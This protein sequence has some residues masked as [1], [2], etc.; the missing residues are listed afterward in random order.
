MNLSSEEEFLAKKFEG[1][2]N[3]AINSYKMTITKF[4]NLREQEILTYIIGQNSGVFLKFSNI[5][6][7]DE[8]KRAIISPFEVDDDFDIDIIKLDYN[9]KFSELNHRQILGTIMS[10]QIERNMIGDI[11]INENKDIYII[12]SKEMSDFIIQNVFKINNSEVFLSKTD[13]VIGSFSPNYVI[14]K[15]FLASLR[16][17]LVTSEGFGV[18]R[19]KVQEM[20]KAGLLKL[21]SKEEKNVSRQIELNDVISLKGHGRIKLLSVGGLSKSG[22]ICVEIGKLK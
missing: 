11:L 9:K 14:K 10:L 2:K 18:S 7:F 1:Y 13:K 5:S 8:Y 19:N 6:G 20:I 3:K 4:L 21:N 22:K 17:D 15:Y 16:I 12:S